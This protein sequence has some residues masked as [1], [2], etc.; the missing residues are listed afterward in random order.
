MTLNPDNISPKRGDRQVKV[1]SPVGKE[2]L[3]MV[4]FNMSLV[5]SNSGSLYYN[6]L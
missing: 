3:F 4:L 1:D 2:L 5:G 6:S